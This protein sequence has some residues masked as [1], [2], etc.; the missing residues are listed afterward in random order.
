MYDKSPLSSNMIRA[1]ISIVI[2]LGQS[3]QMQH[4]PSSLPLSFVHSRRVFT[5]QGG[6]TR[7]PEAVHVHALLLPSPSAFFGRFSSHPSGLLL[8]KFM[9]LVMRFRKKE[10][11]YTVNRLMNLSSFVSPNGTFVFICNIVAFRVEF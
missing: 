3:F 2:T 4:H 10:S 1:Q 8:T 5:T 9:Y 6:L 11:S 7:I